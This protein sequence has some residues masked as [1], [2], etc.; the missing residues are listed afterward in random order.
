MARRSRVVSLSLPSTTSSMA[1][2][3]PVAS[4]NKQG[5]TS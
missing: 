5:E 2:L 3:V 4:L 1:D